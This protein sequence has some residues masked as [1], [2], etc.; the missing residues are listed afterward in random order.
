MLTIWLLTLMV[1]VVEDKRSAIRNIKFLALD[2]KRI[3][4]E[5]IKC[6]STVICDIVSTDGNITIIN[7][8]VVTPRP[9]RKNL[10]NK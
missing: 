9:K 2:H 3:A 8:R 7:C 5:D 10:P 6:A 4:T 1:F